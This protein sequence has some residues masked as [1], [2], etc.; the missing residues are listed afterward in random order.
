M[1]SNY[2]IRDREVRV[3]DSDGSQ[4]GV[5][6]TREALRRAQDNNLDLVKISPN[7]VPPVC[8]IM[9]F[10]KFKY[11]QS[12]K[13]K[14]VRRNQQVS[15]LKEIT[16]SMTIDDHDLK[17]KAGNAHKF[18][19]RGDKCKVTLRMRGR[20]Q[21]HS[22]IGLAVMEDF[23]KQVEDVS[24][25]EKRPAIEGRNII[26]ILVPNKSVST[27]QSQP[28]QPKPQQQAKPAPAADAAATTSI[29]AAIKSAEEKPATAKPTK[30]E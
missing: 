23:F 30:T 29:G 10:G 27:K 2:R 13:D 5:M 3:I 28:Q 22:K 4:L 19:S 9:D 11:E 18:L 1:E 15:E 8:K 20:Q 6:N 25:Q 17:T 26:M 21:A 7:A 12:K 14:E 16:L 24:I